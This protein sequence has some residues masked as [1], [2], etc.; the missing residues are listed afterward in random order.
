MNTQASVAGGT[1]MRAVIQDRYGSSEVLRV[2]EVDIPDVG[3][4]E[5]LIKVHAAGLDRG[6]EH[7][8]TGK[9][10]AMRMVTGLRRP[11]NPVSGRDVA[12]TV[13]KVGSAVTRFVP[14]DEVYGVAPGSFGCPQLPPCSYQGRDAAAAG[15]QGSRQG[16]HLDGD[17][18]V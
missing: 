3:D 6:T 16:R 7:L 9:P 2:S 1:T 13:M 11:K 12:G 10:Y 8:M 18:G 5:V 14:G 15:G 4:N 17:R